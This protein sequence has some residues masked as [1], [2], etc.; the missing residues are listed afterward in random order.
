MPSQRFNEAFQKLAAAEDQFLKSEF[1]APVVSGVE[2]RVRIAGVLCGIRVTPPDF[3]GWGVFR[4]RSHSAADLVRDAGLAERRGYLELFPLVRLVLCLR[5]RGLWLARPAHEG[6]RRFRIEGLVSVRLAE[7]AQ[8]FETV[9][10]RFDGANFWFDAAD[11]ARDPAT[12]AFL[13]KALNDTIGPNQLDRAGLTPEERAAYALNYCLKEEVRQR[14]HAEATE[15]KLREALRHAGAELV[16]YLERRDGYR[17]TWTA[18][19][20]QHVSAVGKGDL[21]V[22]VAG[23]C[24]SGQDRQFDLTSLVG[25]IREAEG[26]GGY[27][28]V[29]R[30][31]AGIDEERYWEV[32]PPGEGEREV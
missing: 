3:E 10:A 15:Q 9:Q 21:A 14:Q 8:Q 12:A 23:I 4:P 28:P 29:G 17:V 27:L 11:P 5:E 1:L 31:N 7:D 13:R 32:H 2:V 24:L 18:G 20:R 26:G 6:D 22:Q 19:G 30:E 16:E 25:V